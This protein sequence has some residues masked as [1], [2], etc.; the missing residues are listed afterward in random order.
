MA[1]H[2][3]RHDHAGVAHLDVRI[4]QCTAQFVAESVLHWWQK[5]GH[6]RFREARKL[7]IVADFNSSR[8]GGWKL[9]LQRLAD[10][11]RLQL[12][13]CML[14]PDTIRWTAISKQLVCTWAPKGRRGSIRDHYAEVSLVGSTSRKDRVPLSEILDS[15][16]HSD[17]KVSRA[18]VAGV[19]QSRHEF[20]GDWNFTISPQ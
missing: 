8:A 14:P 11:T 4:D 13:V 19:K 16:R 1:G 9:A 5:R 15:S 18:A 3:V 7:L 2:V 20:H 12:T 17:R 10:D 6:R